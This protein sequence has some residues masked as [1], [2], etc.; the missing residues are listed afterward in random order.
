MCVY[1]NREGSTKF[2]KLKLIFSICKLLDLRALITH[3][4]SIF[5]AD[6]A[7]IISL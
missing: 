7:T 5:L 4:S 3:N 6:L 1:I 2:T